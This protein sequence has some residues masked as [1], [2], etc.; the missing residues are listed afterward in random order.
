MYQ[1]WAIHME[2][3]GILALPL[4]DD[5]RTLLDGPSFATIPGPPVVRQCS[6]RCLLC[7]EAQQHSFIACSEVKPLELHMLV[8]SQAALASSSLA[9]SCWLSPCLCPQT[10]AQALRSAISLFLH[11]H[12]QEL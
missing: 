10:F 8:P 5:C 7:L 6:V 2:N 1:L 3:S 9:F 11:Q 12:S 4:L